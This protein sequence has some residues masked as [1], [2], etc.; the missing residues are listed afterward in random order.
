[1][2]TTREIINMI[3]DELKNVSDDRFFEDEHIR[4]LIGNYRVFILKQRYSDIRKDIPTSNYQTLCLDLIQVPAISGEPCEGG[5][6]LRSEKEVPN[7]V[8]LGTIMGFSKVT[9]LDY[10]QGNFDFINRERFRY[11]GDNK[12]L[13]NTIYVTLGPDKHL[14]FKSYNP[15]YLY[16]EK[17]K[18]T[19]IFEDF[20]L[21][22]ELECDN[23]NKERICDPLDKEF[24]I[25]VGLIPVLIELVMKELLGALYR[26]KDE[27]NDATDNL[28]GI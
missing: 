26:P 8:S 19:S 21:A 22:S 23:I 9:S 3:Q 20:E 2:A 5:V 28:S 17:I 18:F 24:P 1:M 7:I 16:L 14:Y 27:K 13:K 25:E 4:F 15:Q 12:Y 11:V 10:W 6:Y